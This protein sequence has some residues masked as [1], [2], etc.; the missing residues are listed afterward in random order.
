MKKVMLFLL[1]LA[2]LSTAVVVFSP[3]LRDELHW[4]WTSYHDQAQSYAAYVEAWPDGR[5][6]SEAQALYDERSWSDAT[7]ASA[8]RAFEEYIHHLSNQNHLP[9]LAQLA[10]THSIQ[11]NARS[12]VLT[13]VIPAIPRNGIGPCR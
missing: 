12:G 13:Q 5:H 2:V 7:P 6:A 3:K 10:N 4:R 9:G 1:G 8:V 11:I